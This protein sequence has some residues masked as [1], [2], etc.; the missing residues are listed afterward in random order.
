MRSMIRARVEHVLGSM[1]NEMDGMFIR[2]VDLA[3]AK[4]K[5]G[6]SIWSTT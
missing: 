3:R 5:A 4:T 1:E 2:V 6:L